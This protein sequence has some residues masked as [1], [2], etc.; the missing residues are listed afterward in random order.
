MLVVVCGVPGVG[1]T[2]VAE[3]AVERLG[4]ELFRT[5][6]VRKELFDEP[7]YTDEESLR[8]YEA[9]LG[10]AVPELEAG[11]PA[12]LDGT[13]HDRNYRV[14][15]RSTADRAE[16]NCRFVK[17]EC[18]EAVAKERIRARED[19]VSDAGIE[20]HL[21]FREQFDPLQVE[22]VVV[23]NSGSLSNTHEQVDEL[24]VQAVTR[25]GN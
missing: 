7:Q 18:D 4:A 22:H 10:R 14:A 11:R 1:K 21:M 19:G 25:P 3:H 8:V 12:V 6:V 17:V 2:A 15:A 9:L 5:D 16:V 23:D 24:V 13:F 20:T